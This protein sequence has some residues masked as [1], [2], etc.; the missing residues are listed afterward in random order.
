MAQL[1]I[2]D[3]FASVPRPMKELKGYVR[4]TLEPLESKTVT[5]HL[6][7][8]QLAFYDGELNLVIE[9]GWISVMAGSS[10]SDIRLTGRFEIVGKEKIQVEKRVFVC[11]V[12]VSASK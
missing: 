1:Y 5:F 8:N 7:I 6:P 10:S 9:P 11:P 3:E 4:L 12:E 2:C